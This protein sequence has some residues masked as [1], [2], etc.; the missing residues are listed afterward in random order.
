MGVSQME[1]VFIRHG[2]GEHTLE[3][4]KSLQIG[5]PALTTKGIEQVKLLRETIS[6]TDRDII[7]ISPIR[8]TLETAYILCENNDC[9]KI[10]SP[11]ISPRMFP[12]LQ[13]RH[14]LPCDK[15]TDL[16]V[17]RRDFPTFEID[18]KAPYYLWSEGIN[19]MPKSQFTK[20]AEKFIGR[21]KEFK[22][23]KIYMIS[24]DGTINSYRQ[25]TSGQELS[26]KDFLQETEWVSIQ[27]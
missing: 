1:I 2:E 19:R 5:D 26:R 9:R 12:I 16:E 17:I 11:M 7:V 6:L 4:P 21:C 23:D 20:I 10:V 27:C 3:V 8:R 13:G 25:L 22:K 14:T 18:I 24:H 15:I